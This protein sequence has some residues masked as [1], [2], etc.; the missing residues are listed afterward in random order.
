MVKYYLLIN[1]SKLNLT[2]NVRN[3]AK[4]CTEWIQELL[5]IHIIL[6]GS[7]LIERDPGSIWKIKGINKNLPKNRHQRL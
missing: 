3:C 2:F 6:N 1:Y 7:K 5:A 4:L